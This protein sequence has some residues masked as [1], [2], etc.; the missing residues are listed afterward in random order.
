MQRINNGQH[1]EIERI[2]DTKGYNSK[3]ESLLTELQAANTK[4]DEL[5]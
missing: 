3:I 4:N 5:R 1:D 2:E